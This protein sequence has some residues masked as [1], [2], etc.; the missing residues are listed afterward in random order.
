MGHRRPRAGDQGR[1]GPAEV[2]NSLPLGCELAVGD[3]RRA[4]VVV[5]C[6]GVNGRG[7]QVAPAWRAVVQIDRASRTSRR[8]GVAEV[9]TRSLPTGTVIS[10]RSGLNRFG[11]G[12]TAG[13]TRRLPHL[14]ALGRIIEAMT[15]QPGRPRVLDRRGD[16]RRDPGCAGCQRRAQDLARYDA[17]LDA[18]FVKAREDGD[19][20]VLTVT[21]RRWWFEA[22]AW[23]DP[24]AQRAFLARVD[25]YAAAG[26]PPPGERMS[27]QEFRARPSG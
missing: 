22:D 14:V 9:T 21:V 25:G 6:V 7:P 11:G 4:V 17:E 20:T 8:F 15:A 23:R 26:P 12:P 16:A 2:S 1:A 24:E 10:G 5:T 3:P 27:W 13:R 19:L 18:A